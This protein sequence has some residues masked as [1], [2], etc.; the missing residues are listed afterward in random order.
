MPVLPQLDVVLFDIDDTLYSTTAF[1]SD[2]RR[3]AILA[4]I[5]Q[6]L[7]VAEEEGVRELT[8]V[9]AEF[10][11]NYEQH[12]DRLLDRLGPRAAGAAATP[13]S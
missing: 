11:S 13:P 7:D 8:E 10:T 4:M 6:G 9:V 5:H 3:N 12:L 1:A 2:A